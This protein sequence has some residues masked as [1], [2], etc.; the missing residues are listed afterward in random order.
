MAAA[1][2]RT[3]AEGLRQVTTTPA[4]PGCRRIAAAPVLLRRVQEESVAIDRRS[5]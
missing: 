1:A 3:L 2:V 4:R 5:C